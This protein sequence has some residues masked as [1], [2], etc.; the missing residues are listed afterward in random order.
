MQRIHP[1]H[2]SQIGHSKKARLFYICFFI[3]SAFSIRP[4][5]QVNNFDYRILRSIAETRTPGQNN[6]F[7]FISKYN[8]PVCLAAPATLFITGLI[9]DDVQMK[10]SS[11]YVTESI[12]SASLFNLI[13]KKIFKRKRPFINDPTFTAV[14]FARNESFPS[15]H[16]AE[17]F[18]MASSMTFAYPRWYVILPTF[19]WAG[20]VGYARMYL[21]VHYPTDVF[22]GATISSGMSWLLY[23]ANRNYL[24]R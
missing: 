17:A 14:V 16:T 8:N 7:K 10:R 1:S 12:A 21:G 5:A 24:R 22:A 3:T 6:F 15:G 13:L 2:L 11:L 4:Y 23:N 18:S 20:L 19:G 9:K